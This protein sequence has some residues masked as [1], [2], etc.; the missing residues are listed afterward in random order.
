M[1]AKNHPYRV[2][3]IVAF[4]I[5]RIDRKYLNWLIKETGG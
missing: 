5:D 3:E 1:I 2:P 4:H